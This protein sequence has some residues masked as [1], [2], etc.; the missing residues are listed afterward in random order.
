MNKSN[1][2][3]VWKPIAMNVKPNFKVI[4]FVLVLISWFHKME[5]GCTCIEDAMEILLRYCNLLFS[6]LCLP[7]V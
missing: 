4:Q 6:Y 5:T 2:V 7:F 3:R 1:F